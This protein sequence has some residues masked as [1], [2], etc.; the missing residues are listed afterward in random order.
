[1]EQSDDETSSAATLTFFNEAFADQDLEA[2]EAAPALETFDDGN[3]QERAKML[4]RAR[5]AANARKDMQEFVYKGNLVCYQ[6]DVWTHDGGDETSCAS[7][8]EWPILAALF[9]G[10]GKRPSAPDDVVE[11][12]AVPDDVIVA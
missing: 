4:E 7:W 3:A 8:G 9:G 12:P 5:V 11:R 10:G 2:T 6:K 1:M